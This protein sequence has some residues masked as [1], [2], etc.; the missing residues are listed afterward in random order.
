[1]HKK[2]ELKQGLID[3]FWEIYEAEGTLQALSWLE[4]LK[5]Y[6]QYCH[7]D[8]DGITGALRGLNI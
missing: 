6:E 1:M 5:Y 2:T 8:I 4:T 7:S 3:R